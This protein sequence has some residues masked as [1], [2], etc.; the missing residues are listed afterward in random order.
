MTSKR[1]IAHS[2][3][4]ELEGFVPYMKYIPNA[5]DIWR[6][7]CEDIFFF[8]DVFFMAHFLFPT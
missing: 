8:V 4:Y 2:I 1:W 3:C 7:F 5:E 6:L